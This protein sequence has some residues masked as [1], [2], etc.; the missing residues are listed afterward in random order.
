MDIKRQCICSLFYSVLLSVIVGMKTMVPASME[1][2]LRQKHNNWNYRDQKERSFFFMDCVI[3]WI[4][5]TEIRKNVRFF[6]RLCYTVNRNY[7]DKKERSFYYRL[8]VIL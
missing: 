2:Y 7:G 5:T 8:C 6:N 4:G 3:L 1:R